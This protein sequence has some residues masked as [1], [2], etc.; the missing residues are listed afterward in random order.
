MFGKDFI[1]FPVC[2]N[3]HWYLAII[4]YPRRILL[5][6]DETAID[7]P[8]SAGDIGTTNTGTVV[9]ASLEPIIDSDASPIA[10]GRRVSS[11]PTTK[12]RTSGDRKDD[13]SNDSDDQLTRKYDGHGCDE[14]H[15]VIFL[16]PFYSFRLDV[17]L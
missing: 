11:R 17:S 8:L 16:Y 6:Q 1:F 4:C 3:L 12:R 9:N 7:G 14:C 13:N 5:P 15:C 2:E 10:S